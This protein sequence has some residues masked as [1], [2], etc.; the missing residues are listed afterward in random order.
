[1]FSLVRTLPRAVR[2]AEVDR[3]P[4]VDAQL[5]VLG[6]LGALVPGQR[7]AQ[8]VGQRGDRG[9]DG[10]AD[11]FGAVPGE[12]RPVL[13]SR[14]VAVAVHAWQVQQHREP[15]GALDERADRRAVETDDEVALPV[16]G[17]RSIVGLGGSL[18][19]HHLR[20]DELLAP[21]RGARP[22]DAQRPP[23]AQTGDQL[24][25]QRSPALH[26]QRLID[27]LVRDAHRLIIGEV[28]PQPVRDLL[29]APRLR[30]PPILTA[31]MTSTDPAHLRA[32][33]PPHRRGR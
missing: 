25:A 20:A 33:A 9:G 23:G 26:V 28:D 15:G 29:R 14:A 12:R 21:P 2:V 11:G 5:D 32:R 7:S 8:L 24:A 22:G 19:D 27:G 10:V 13:D 31:T 18:A 17:H 16:A 6:H 4:G 30:P 3:Q 1:M